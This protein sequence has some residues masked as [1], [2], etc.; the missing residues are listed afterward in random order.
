MQI[1]VPTAGSHK[2]AKDFVIG[3]AES[4]TKISVDEFFK[5]VHDQF[6]PDKNISFMEDFLT[7]AEY[8]GKFI[9][10][11]TKLVEYGVVVTT[12]ANSM[13]VLTKQLKL[14]ESKDFVERKGLYFLTPEAF[15]KCLLQKVNSAKYV[16]YYLL[17]ERIF[18][19]YTMYQTLYLEKLLSRKD[20][21]MDTII[22]RLEELKVYAADT[23]AT[24][25]SFN[26]S[27][28]SEQGKINTA[29]GCRLQ[30]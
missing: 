6:Y 15:K 24:T 25:N 23:N 8:D 4:L 19:L 20:D 13:Q 26:V 27:R 21:Q 1:I 14:V 3:L 11:Y 5:R 28:T 2:L 7:L 18:A 9:V 17:L 16:E 30:A 10:H 12:L 29:N 22:D